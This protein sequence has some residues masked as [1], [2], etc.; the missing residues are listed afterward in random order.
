MCLKVETELF[1]LVCSLTGI[2][3][4]QNS[5]PR[6]RFAPFFSWRPLPIYTTSLFTAS[7]FWLNAFL[8]GLF[9]FTFFVL[10]ETQFF[11]YAV[12]FY[13]HFFSNTTRAYNKTIVY[14]VC[15]MT[16]NCYNISSVPVFLFY[17]RHQHWW[18]LHV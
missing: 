4:L 11:I 3:I 15:H 10:L 1:I 6:P 5:T 14:I 9:P 18:T 13:V 2:R 17:Q 7:H 12:L 8:A 16:S